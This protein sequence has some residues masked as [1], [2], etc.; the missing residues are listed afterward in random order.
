MDHRKIVKDETTATR[1]RL[2]GTSVL[3]ADGISAAPGE[4]GTP[5]ISIDG[6]ALTSDGVGPLVEPGGSGNGKGAYYVDL[7]AATVVAA[8]LGQSGVVVLETLT[9]RFVW[10][11]WEVVANDTVERV[12]SAVW[13]EPLTG[14]TYNGPTT[15]GRRVRQ[16]SGTI[17]EGTAQGPGVGRNQIVLDLGAPATDDL[18]DPSQITTVGG[19]GEKQSR[20]IL[21]YDYDHPQGPTCTL[22]RDWKTLPAADTEFEITPH[23]GREHVNEGAIRG[24][25]ANT[26]RLNDKASDE[27]D[28]I[29]DQMVFMRSGP[30]AYDQ[31]RA[32]IAWDGDTQTATVDPWSVIPGVGAGYSL[33]P[34]VA[35]AK[36]VAGVREIV[37]TVKDQFGANF[38]GYTLDIFDATG[39]HEG[40]VVDT[41]L[42]GVI[43][44]YRNDATFTIRIVAAQFQPT[45]T[46]ETLTV[47]ADAAVEYTGTRFV[48]P[49]AT[50]PN[51]CTVYG[52]A[53]NGSEELQDGVAITFTPKTTDDDL[54]QITNDRLTV[55]TGPT[56]ENPSWPTGYWELDLKRGLVANVWSAVL[57]LANT[58]TVP[59]A[60][61][62]PLDDLLLP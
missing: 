10:D 27:D 12:A 58:I 11:S 55:T 5:E 46:P 1:L 6:G 56:A 60:A 13:S 40:S 9:A 53:T 36:A 32:I 7:D 49:A 54:N 16:L 30:D 35:T 33:L 48:P 61:S 14:A 51:L 23:V 21:E 41:D 62:S 25:T 29:L 44:M 19:T 28:T 3:K 50:D 24:A 26:V 37:V 20:L 18:L 17:Y 2:K 31:V 42:D 22:D 4:T 39:R 8:N 34:N 45:N 52:Y 38:P 15:A 59:D 43:T 47:T 57:E